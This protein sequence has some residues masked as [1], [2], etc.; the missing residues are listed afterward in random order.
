MER[1]ATGEG[2]GARA[3]VVWVY[4]RETGKGRQGDRGGHRR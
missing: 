2:V 4:R 3:R 1:L